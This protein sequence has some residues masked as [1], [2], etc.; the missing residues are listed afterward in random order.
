LHFY[1]IKFVV[2]SKTQKSKIYHPALN[3]CS[4]T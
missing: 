1:E 4:R 3:V 2:H